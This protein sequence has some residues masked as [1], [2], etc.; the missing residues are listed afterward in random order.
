MTS[1]QDLEAIAIRALDQA[2]DGPGL[3]TLSTR[4]IELG[5]SVSVCS[6]DRDAIG[7]GI[8]KAFDAGA[9]V[10]Q[11]Q[12]VIALISGLGVHSLM[13]SA[14]PVLM[15]AE[16]RGVLDRSIDARRQEL[17]DLHVGDDPFWNGFEE[18]VPGFLH[19]MLVLS[20]ELFEGFFAYCGIP[21]KSG[22]VRAVTKELV[23]MASDATPSHRFA[24]GFRIHLH[25]A[26]ALGASKAMVRDAVEIAA[27]TPAHNGTS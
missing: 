2:Q 4:L 16:R 18:E 14:V 7:S 17:W 21:W 9:T 24:P 3:D 25:N 19:A 13:V 12:E 26:I 6:L 23:A 10:D 5:C 11:I 20:P 15:I 27:R 1:L 8:E 22:T